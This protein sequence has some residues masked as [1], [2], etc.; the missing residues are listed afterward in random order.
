MEV[1]GNREIS[2]EELREVCVQSSN[3]FKE[4]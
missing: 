1:G 2:Q 3:V 4:E